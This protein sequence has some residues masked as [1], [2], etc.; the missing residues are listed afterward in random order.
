ML[1]R[2]NFAIS[3]WWFLTRPQCDVSEQEVRSPDFTF[4]SK[5]RYREDVLK[6]S[7]WQLCKIYVIS[8]SKPFQFDGIS[9]SYVS[10]VE[11]Y[12]HLDI[13]VVFRRYYVGLLCIAA[14]GNAWGCWF[15]WISAELNRALICNWFQARHIDLIVSMFIHSRPFKLLAHLNSSIWD[16]RTPT[17]PWTA[18]LLFNTSMPICELVMTELSQ[19]FLTCVV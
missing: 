12:I 16:T 11:S 7:L 14:R 15:R 8:A 19:C 5:Q 9:S 3:W 18:T 6:S 1:S 2:Q 17:H 13:Q 10:W 4:A